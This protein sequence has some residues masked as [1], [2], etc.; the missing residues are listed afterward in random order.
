MLKTTI[1]GKPG[2]VGSIPGSGT[3]RRHRRMHD[4]FTPPPT[5]R[6]FW[7]VADGTDRLPGRPLVSTPDR[8]PA[9]LWT[10]R[11]QNKNVGAYDMAAVRITLGYPRFRLG[12]EIAATMMELAP[13]RAMFRMTD[14]AEF[15]TAYR[16]KLDVVGFDM[17][18]GRL[19]ALHEDTGQPVVLLCFE[20]P[21][22][23]C[24][25]FELSAWLAERGVV[26]VEL[27]E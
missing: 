23:W 8:N 12:Y 24:H 10:A 11:Y 17:I 22:E 13:S 20:K 2:D 6:A 19:R 26:V 7:P 27:C 15:A 4:E 25:R 5:Q 21:G 18:V 14:V 16:A 3:Q 9:W 1:R